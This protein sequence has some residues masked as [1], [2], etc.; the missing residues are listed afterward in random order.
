M[1]PRHAGPIAEIR[2]LVRQDLPAVVALEQHA[3]RDPW[4]ESDFWDSLSPI[5]AIGK[6]A[7]IGDRIVGHMVYRL[8]GDHIAIDCFTVDPHYRNQGVARQMLATLTAQAASEPGGFITFDIN[9]RE[10]PTQQV[11]RDLGFKATGVRRGHFEPSGDDAYTMRYDPPE[12][13]CPHR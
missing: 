1:P 5:N 2:W 8:C 10:L 9:E 11:L 7:Q 4:S 12:R 6:V 3:A 13:S